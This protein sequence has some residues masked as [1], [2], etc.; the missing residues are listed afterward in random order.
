MLVGGWLAGGMASITSSS[1]WA[2]GI[3]FWPVLGALT[4][5][6]AEQTTC[7]DPTDCHDGLRTALWVMDA[8]VQAAGLVTLLVGLSSGAKRLERRPLVIGP[9]GISGR[10]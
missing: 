3:G 10:F 7:Y 4:E 2:R 9:G 5:A 8:V 6:G 1:S